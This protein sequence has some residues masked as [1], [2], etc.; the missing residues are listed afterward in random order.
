MGLFRTAFSHFLLPFFL[1]L[2]STSVFSTD[3]GIEQLKKALAK[4]M[5]RTEITQVR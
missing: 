5:P 2:A 1:L 4:N 3:D